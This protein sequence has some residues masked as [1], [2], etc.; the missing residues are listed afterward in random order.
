MRVILKHRKEE[1]KLC[2]IGFS[3]TLLLFG[4][5]VP[6][7]RGNFIWFV[8]IALADILTLGIAWLVLP[9]IYNNLYMKYLL[10]RGYYP[11]TRRDEIMLITLKV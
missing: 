5:L 2:P 11:S 4:P 3:W 8:Y 9:F 6:L 10:R 7:L 1:A